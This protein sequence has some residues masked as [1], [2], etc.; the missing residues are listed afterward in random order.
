VSGG[1]AASEGP[2]FDPVLDERKLAALQDVMTAH[3]GVVRSSESL[4]AALAFIEDLSLSAKA[5]S[6]L[7]NVAETAR[8]M[9]VS[10][11]F[12]D[13]SRGAHYRSDFPEL[14]TKATRTMITSNSAKVL[15][16]EILQ[17]SAS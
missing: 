13:E 3:V 12:R 8:M 5:S 7:A 9:A 10:G 15:A 17:G 4:R 2:V 16:E 1:G 14:K 6:P 11:F